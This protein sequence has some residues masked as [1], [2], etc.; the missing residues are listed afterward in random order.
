MAGM[1]DDARLRSLLMWERDLLAQ[2]GAGCRSALGVLATLEEGR[3]RLDAFVSDEL[4][5]RQTVVIGDDGEAVV[6]GARKE[7][8]L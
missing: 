2:T 6:A 1:L 7:L 5:P 4:G 8:G 3:I